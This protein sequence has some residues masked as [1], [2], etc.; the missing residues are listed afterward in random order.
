MRLQRRS[1]PMQLHMKV[2]YRGR[3]RMGAW[4]WVF[5]DMQVR[6]NPLGCRDAPA[7]VQRC[8][9]LFM[10]VRKWCTRGH[11]VICMHL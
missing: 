8:K 9:H 11:M 10:P 3:A 6:D 4:G 7:K 1:T 2:A 5:P